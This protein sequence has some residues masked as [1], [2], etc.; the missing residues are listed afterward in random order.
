MST[1]YTRHLLEENYC[2]SEMSKFSELPKTT[3]ASKRHKFILPTNAQTYSSGS[4]GY[5]EFIFPKQYCVDPKTV[6]LEFQ[7]VLSAAANAASGF[8]CPGG[9]PDLLQRIKITAGSV[10][11]VD[12]D[13][14]NI[15]WNFLLKWVIPWDYTISTGAILEGVQ[16][17]FFAEADQHS[18]IPAY[19]NSGGTAPVQ[20]VIPNLKDLTNGSKA[21]YCS[22]IPLAG[23]FQVMSYLP[24]F[25]FAEMKIQL[26]FETATRGVTASKVQPAASQASGFSYNLSNFKLYFDEVV[27]GKDLNAAMMEL[28]AQNALFIPFINIRRIQHTFNAGSSDVTQTITD[29]LGSIKSIIA[30]P[31]NRN[32]DTENYPYLQLHQLPNWSQLD[33]TIDGEPLPTY[34]ISNYTEKYVHCLRSLGMYNELSQPAQVNPMNYTSHPQYGIRWDGAAVGGAGN[35]YFPTADFYGFDFEREQCPGMLSGFDSS[36]RSL[37]ININ[38]KTSSPNPVSFDVHTFLTHDAHLIVQANGNCVIAK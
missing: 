23:L 22:H 6:H 27:P 2:V 36:A 17:Q 34:K 16:P 10:D 1:A 20:A 35:L 26:W 25:L 32:L 21:V 24:A 14:Y 12:V 4:N 5:I 13:G 37:D 33:F 18:G 9:Y 29:R 28:A 8:G 15:W 30:I 11:L 38:L 19:P 3:I 31:I 7:V